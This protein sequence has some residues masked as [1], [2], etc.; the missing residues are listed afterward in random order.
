MAGDALSYVKGSFRCQ[1]DIDDALAFL[2]HIDQAIDEEL[3]SRLRAMAIRCE[4]EHV[5][6]YLWRTFELDSSQGEVSLKGSSLTLP[7]SSIRSHLDGATHASLLAVTIG[8]TWHRTTAQLNATS[9]TDALL[10]DACASALTE[11]A[12]EE[13]HCLLATAAQ[14]EGLEAHA[15]FSP[16]YGD[17]PLSIQP[18][19]LREID[20]PRQ[21]GVTTT[22]SYFLEPAKSTTAIV[23]L[24][25]P[26][27]NNGEGLHLCEVCFAHGYCNFR[28]H[29]TTCHGRSGR[30]GR[31]GSSTG[32]ATRQREREAQ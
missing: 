32:T 30:S 28:A 25:R 2:G 10:Y 13:A 12:I 21:I 27:A 9:A 5:P 26:G 11:S 16:G 8:T 29:G 22:E 4:E 15:R 20:A 23:G 18:S 17:L 3:L 7:G 1:V 31:S 14:K 19:F 24:F 6:R